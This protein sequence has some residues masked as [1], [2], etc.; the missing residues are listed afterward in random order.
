[1]LAKSV[2]TA[3]HVSGGRIDLGMGAGWMEEEYR[4]YGFA[5]PPIGVRLAQLEESLEILTRLFTRDSTTFEG[6]HYTFRD[7]PFAPKPLQSPMPITLGGSGVRVFMRLV[8]RYASCWNIPMTAV[9]RLREH[10]DA[11]ARHCDALG[12]DPA[13]IVV[14]EQACVVLGRDDAALKEK[15]AMAKTFVGGWVDLK[16]MAVC[17]TPD[18]VAESLRA[19]MAAGVRDFAIVFGDL[20]MPD[21]LELFMERVAPQL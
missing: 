2:V 16:T 6:K 20:G 11:L 14:S 15:L 21:T 5:F 9:P 17:G 13:S 12:R 3:D 18:R 8:A 10:L 4:A 19:K 7:A 1:M